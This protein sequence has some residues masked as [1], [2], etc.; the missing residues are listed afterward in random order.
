[1]NCAV[2]RCDVLWV[3]R[4]APLDLCAASVRERT[5]AVTLSHIVD[6]RVIGAN[7]FG[8]DKF[9]AVACCVHCHRPNEADG[10]VCPSRFIVRYLEEE[11][12]HNLQYSREVSVRRLAVYWLELFNRIGE[13]RHNLFGRH[14]VRSAWLQ[15][16]FG[17]IHCQVLYPFALII[18]RKK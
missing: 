11:R 8:F 3:P 4:P 5:T 17:P 12:R 18:H 1:M 13:F 6:C 14:G 15:E 16:R 10:V 7:S 2:F 9:R